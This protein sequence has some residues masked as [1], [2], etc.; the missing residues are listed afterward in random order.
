MTDALI[1]AFCFQTGAPAKR[2]DLQ[3]VR[4]WQP[5]QGLMWAH[6]D[7][8]SPDTLGYLDQDSV[9]PPVV[10]EA[11]VARETRP[12]CNPVGAGLVLVLRGVNLNSGADPED[13]VS[14]RIFV[15]ENRIISTRQRK[16]L[17]VGDAAESLQHRSPSGTADILLRILDRL[18]GRINR[19]IDTMEDQAAELEENVVDTADKSLRTRLSGQRREAILLRRYLAPQR[20]ALGRL[21]ADMPDWFGEM[22]RLHLREIYDRQVRLVEDLDAVRE[23]LTVIHEELV[24]RLSDQLNQRMYVLSIVA[25]LFLPLGFLTGLLGIN[26]AGIPGADYPHAFW[27]F[28]GFLAVLVTLQV[29]FF[30][31]KRWF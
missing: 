30:L 10:A 20:E 11:L 17:S 7:A 9:L 13:M 19:V 1:H 24:S 26:V 8:N 5:E 29:G 21:L 12:R 14:I 25:A 2:L 27:I 4:E 15:E 22:E 3:Q 16:L 6:F 23:R 18:V 31:R 28:L